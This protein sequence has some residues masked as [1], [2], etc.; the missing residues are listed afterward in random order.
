[1]APF[2]L[3]GRGLVPL[4][5]PRPTPEG[6]GLEPSTAPR[7]PEGGAGNDRAAAAAAEAATVGS[8]TG[9]AASTVSAAALA[10]PARFTCRLDINGWN[11]SPSP[12]SVVRA[13]N[14]ANQMVLRIGLSVQKVQTKT[15]LRFESL[16]F[17]LQKVFP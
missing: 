7:R 6:G 9:C 3:S 2:A 14:F 16:Y 17:Q 5:T 10:S 11:P 13:L 1:V 8:T 12:C 15:G 4:A